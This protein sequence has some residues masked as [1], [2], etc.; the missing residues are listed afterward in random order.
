MKKILSVYVL[1]LAVFLLFSCDSKRDDNGDLLF[2]VQYPESP[3]EQTRFLAEMQTHSLSFDGDTEDQ[4]L[5]F[6]YNQDKLT[7]F[8]DMNGGS[9]S[10]ITY[11][12]AN[13]ISRIS[14]GGITSTFLYSGTHVSKII[15]EVPGM[16]KITTNYTFS[17]NQLTKAETITEISKPVPVEAYLETTYA[18]TGSNVVKASVKSGMYDANGDLQMSENQVIVDYTYDGKKNPYRLLPEELAVYLSGLAP[19]SAGYLSA[20]NITK[21]EYNGENGEVKSEVF[22]NQ[23][24]PKDYLLKSVSAGESSTFIYR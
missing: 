17:G 4:H 20:N 21:Y 11:N 18:Y 1:F 14:S 19:Q 16:S 12:S 7:S 5:K 10:Q 2:G 9:I 6:V 13:K 3:V 8:T 23:Y 24:D 15:T 22:Q